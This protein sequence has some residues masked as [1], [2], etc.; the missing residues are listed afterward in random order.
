MHLP[1][2]RQNL[3]RRNDRDAACNLSHR[4][5]RISQRDCLME[6]GSGPTRRVQLGGRISRERQ[7]SVHV[8]GLISS[9]LWRPPAARAWSWSDRTGMLTWLAKTVLGPSAAR[10]QIKDPPSPDY[11]INIA[12]A[13]H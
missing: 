6:G 3:F 10:Y 5:G 11:Q 2:I 8:G 1:L 13:S 7:H 9:S 4:C 12:L